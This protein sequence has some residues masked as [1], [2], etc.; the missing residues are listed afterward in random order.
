MKPVNLI[1][2]CACCLLCSMAA[3][4][5]NPAADTKQEEKE[6]KEGPYIISYK[7]ALLGRLYLSRRYT[8]LGLQADE[9][10]ELRYRPNT[11]VI[12]GV[13]VA[14]RGLSVSLGTGFDFLNPN[15]KEKGR[16]RS[17]DFR[18]HLY[19]R[20]WVTDLYAQWY[21]GY[22]I[23][24]SK[25]ENTNG[26][27]YY[28]RPDIK[29]SLLGVSV[30]RL[31]NGKRFSYQAGFSQNEWQKKSAGSLLIGA[32]VY[33]GAVKGDSALVPSYLAGHYPQ[34]E[35]YRVRLLEFGPG[36][37]YA[38]TA[39][40]KEHFFATGGLTVN[41]DMSLVKESKPGSSASHSSP[42]PNAQFRMVG[43][44]TNERWAATLGWIHNSTNAKGPSSNKHYRI[45][46]GGFSFTVARRFG[47]GP[48]LKKKLDPIVEKLP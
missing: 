38:Y 6:E 9:T 34:R 47:A 41:F 16:T 4:Q 39:V 22:Y 20:H 31:L 14:Y 29:A 48:K 2:L 42:S 44:Y 17:F 37:G 12:T 46:T 26:K 27:P 24:Q 10:N 5:K 3:A 11:F 1:I 30:Y 36:I 35:V 33:Y 7:Q 28:V 19:S 32:E 23:N 18:T 40:W 15:R 43:G 21:R 45:K 25:F 8:S 13:N